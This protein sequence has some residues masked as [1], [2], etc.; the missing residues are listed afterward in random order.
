MIN[1]RHETCNESNIFYIP[2]NVD[3]PMVQE[4][5]KIALD[6]RKDSFAKVASVMIDDVFENYEDREQIYDFLCMNSLQLPA[7]PVIVVDELDFWT[8]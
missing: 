8:E 4:L 5:F 7:V 2:T 1:Y 3:N 6:S